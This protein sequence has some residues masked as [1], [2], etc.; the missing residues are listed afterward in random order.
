MRGLLLATLV[1]AVIAAL[2][3][4]MIVARPE[5]LGAI[6]L[7]GPAFLVSLA[8]IPRRIPWQQRVVLLM[9]AALMLIAA[10][11]RV[12]FAL[13]ME[14]DKVLMGIS[15]CWVPQSALA[16]IFLTLGILIFYYR[17]LSNAP[18]A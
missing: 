11:I 9:P 7:F 12:G 14:L 3:R 1:V 17:R 8:M 15:V 5:V 4:E 18:A 2:A 13:G 16:A 6:Y 10:A